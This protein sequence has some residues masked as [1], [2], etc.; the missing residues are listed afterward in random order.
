MPEVR[1]ARVLMPLAV[2]IVALPVLADQWGS[3][4]AAQQPSLTAA[5][6]VQAFEFAN[7]DSSL[8]LIGGIVLDQSGALNRALNA[9]ET[10][11]LRLN[12]GYTVGETTGYLTL[13]G[14]Q[15]VA[16]NSH[17]FGPVVGLGM[18]VSLNHGVQ[19]SGEILHHET[20]PNAGGS[21]GRSETLSVR[22]A[23]RF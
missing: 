14:L 8:M 9:D 5:P 23:F 1:K 18:R 12:A 19:L 13:G 2:A 6:A 4:P 3:R 11:Q 7:A 16:G 15:A 20:A 21:Q 10:H 22:A 17:W